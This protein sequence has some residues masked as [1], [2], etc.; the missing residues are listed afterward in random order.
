MVGNFV[1]GWNEQ[2]YFSMS[3]TFSGSEVGAPQCTSV[4]FTCTYTGFELGGTAG[5]VSGCPGLLNL[6]ISA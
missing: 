1:T 6:A 3:M 4:A 2:V 5:R